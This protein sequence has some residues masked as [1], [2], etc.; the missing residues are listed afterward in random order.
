MATAAMRKDGE[1]LVGMKLCQHIKANCRGFTID[2]AVSSATGFPLHFS[3][4]RQ[5]ESNTDNYKR[6]LQFMFSHL[7]SRGEIMHA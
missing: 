5:G 3:V 2:S 6:M 4:L 1:Y 7:F